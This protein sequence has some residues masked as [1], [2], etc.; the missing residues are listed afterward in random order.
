MG[1]RSLARAGQLLGVVATTATMAVL[2]ATPASAAPPSNDVISGATAITSVPFAETVDT[3]EATTDA[4]D[5]AIN[6]QCGAPATN[7]SVWYTLTAGD[8]AGYVFD[9]SQSDFS[10]GVIVATGTPGALEIYACGPV[11]IAIPVTPGETYYVMAFS[12]TPEVVG[13]QLSFAVSEASPPPDV[14]MTVD[15]TGRANKDGTATISGTYT[16][17]GTAELV[18]VQGTLQQEQQNGVQVRGSFENA[19]L[20]C[21]GTSNWKIQVTPE[22]GKFKRGLAATIA[23][24]VGCSALGCNFYETL[25][26]VRLRGGSH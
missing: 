26:V 2:T 22:S 8:V 13:G 18:V 5:A 20:T 19:A 16:C 15:D 10:A 12:D 3:T 9:V 14:S 21:D 24:T 11:S 25:E 1:I 17:E 23:L 7:G 6:A 4:E